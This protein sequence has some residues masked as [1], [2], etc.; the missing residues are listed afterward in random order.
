M[1]DNHAPT[2]EAHE[3]KS[4][5]KMYLWIFLLLAVLTA[6]EIWIAEIPGISVFNKGTAL[7]LLAFAKAFLVAYFYMHLNEETK[8]L[9]LI[10]AVPILAGIYAVVLGLESYFKPF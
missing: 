9:K 10:A 4:H 1:S 8:W 7:T 6:I 5:K 2:T 3:H